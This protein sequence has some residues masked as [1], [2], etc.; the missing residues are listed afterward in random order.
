MR[1]KV[2]D[3]QKSDVHPLPL[4]PKIRTVKVLV[5]TAT[6]HDQKVATVQTARALISIWTGP[7]LL[8]LS[9]SFTRANVRM[10]K[11]RNACWASATMQ[12]TVANIHT[13]PNIR[14]VQ[15]ITLPQPSV[16][17]TTLA[18]LR[19]RGTFD[20]CIQMARRS[21]IRFPVRAAWK[22]CN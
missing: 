20:C 14:K 10:R 15:K 6:I 9:L 18:P 1:N 16:P 8:L 5:L 22:K 13:V 11:I 21:N 19:N 12:A 7:M 17:V 3:S 4:Q 2:P